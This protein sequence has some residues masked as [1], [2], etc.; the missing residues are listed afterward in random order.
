MTILHFQLLSLTASTGVSYTAS[1]GIFD[2][3]KYNKKRKISGG[4]GLGC[5]LADE[6][7]RVFEWPHH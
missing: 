1:C 3:T 5:Y 7:Y 2:L 6:L 4:D